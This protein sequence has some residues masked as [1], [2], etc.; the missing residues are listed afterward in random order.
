M[1]KYQEV[2]NSILEDS[3]ASM[4]LDSPAASP[5]ERRDWW[6]KRLKLDLRM[7]G[8]MKTLDAELLGPWR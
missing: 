6:R 5:L 4:R 3:A 2:L 8:L 1:G 7:A